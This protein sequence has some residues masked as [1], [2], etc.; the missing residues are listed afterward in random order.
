MPYEKFYFNEL[1]SAD[2]LGIIRPCATLEEHSGPGLDYSHLGCLCLP[3]YYLN[4]SLQGQLFCEE[5][6]VANTSQGAFV[7]EILD[8]VEGKDKEIPSLGRLLLFEEFFGCS[9]SQFQFILPNNSFLNHHD[10][11][12]APSILKRYLSFKQGCFPCRTRFC[13]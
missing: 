7:T 4:R 8:K 10:T 13:K 1:F 6:V 9:F 5:K 11:L 12:D 3:S 2:C